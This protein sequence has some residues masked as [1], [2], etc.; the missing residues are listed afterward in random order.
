MVL[1]KVSLTGASSMLGLHLINKLIKNNYKILALSRTRP[2]IKHKNLIYKKFDIKKKYTQEKFESFFNNSSIIIHAGCTSN[3]KKEKN[4]KNAF[5]ANLNVTRKIGLLAN[6]NEKKL[7][8]I[9]GAIIYKNQKNKNNENSIQKR[10]TKD[11]YVKSKIISEKLLLKLKKRG[12][13]LLILRPSSIYGFGQKK[14]KIITKLVSRAK[15]KKILELYDLDSSINL[16]H[17][18]DVANFIIKSIKSKKAK[19]IFNLGNKLVNYRYIANELK[20]I[21]KCKIISKKTKLINRKNTQTL[22]V[23]SKKSNLILNWRAKI[24]LNRG[25]LSIKN[26]EIL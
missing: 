15:K 24:N 12:L 21:F 3:Y 19:G 22:D 4:K 20:K 14:N 18:A 11:Y 1:N 25:L 10:N 8:F 23:S 7:I 16:I 9:S 2:K 26:H 5:L 17:A 13:N 6:S